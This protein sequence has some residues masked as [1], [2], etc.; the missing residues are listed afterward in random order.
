MAQTMKAGILFLSELSFDGGEPLGIPPPKE[1]VSEEFAKDKVKTTPQ[2]DCLKC[3]Q[4]ILENLQNRMVKSR[5][6]HRLLICINI[7]FNEKSPNVWKSFGA[8]IAQK[9]DLV[10]IDNLF[11]V[12]LTDGHDWI[13]VDRGNE[14]NEGWI[15]SM[16][17]FL[18]FPPRY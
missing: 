4:I 10:G 14:I 18:T 2:Q 16:D 8:E 12:T 11:T 13:S 6:N 15:H 9:D 5:T 7:I 17:L 1:I 3:H